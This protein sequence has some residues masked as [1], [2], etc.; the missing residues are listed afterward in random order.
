MQYQ[1]YLVFLVSSRDANQHMNSIKYASEH[2]M[3][4]TGTYFE[5]RKLPSGNE[6]FDWESYE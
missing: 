2:W 6:D 4:V 1:E 3:L 5:V